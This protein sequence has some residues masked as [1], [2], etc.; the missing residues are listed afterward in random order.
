M[1]EMSSRSEGP[2][3]GI[4]SLEIDRRRFLAMTGAGA[5]LASLPGVVDAAIPVEYPLSVGYVEG[6]DRLAWLDEMPWHVNEESG[7]ALPA[8]EIPSG[9][10]ALALEPLSVRICGLYPD[11][12][13]PK[14][15]RPQEIDLDVLFEPF[16]PQVPSPLP[17]AAW[18][19]RRLPARNI[20]APVRF[21]IEMGESDGLG[22]RLRFENLEGR[23][24]QSRTSFTVDRSPGLPR[25]QR[26]LYLLGLVPG[27]FDHECKL[28]GLGEA[29]DY[30]LRSI[31]ISV[32]GLPTLGSGIKG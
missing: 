14:K 24:Y 28:P 8:A 20:S 1:A 23:V 7:L 32:E 25:L 31:A 19:F 16:D 2:L 21:T 13:W 4:R 29:L 3:A 26:G 9:D 18:S 5:A 10:P 6:S 15:L 30:R 12:P 17:F 22:L 11:W 27:T